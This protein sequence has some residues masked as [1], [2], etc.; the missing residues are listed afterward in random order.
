MAKIEGNLFLLGVRGTVGKQMVFRVWNGKTIFSKYPR[1]PKS[2]SDAQKE[3]INRFREATFYA[4]S[5][6]SDE[7]L[8]RGYAEKAQNSGGG[9]TAYNVAIAD[10]LNGPVVRGINL[11]GYGGGAGERIVVSAMDDFLV[12]EV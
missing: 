10:Y 3:Q 4:K 5:V 6:L 9:L 7:D 8:R 1:R 11:E 2:L 12:K